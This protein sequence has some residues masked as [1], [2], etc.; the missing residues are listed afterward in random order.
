MNFKS[1]DH[2]PYEIINVVVLPL[3]FAGFTPQLKDLHP[4]WH[5]RIYTPALVGALSL[6]PAS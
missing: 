1:I 5:S 4:A 6:N 3:V 2:M